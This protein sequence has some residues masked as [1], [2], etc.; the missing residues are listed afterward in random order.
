MKRVPIIFTHRVL[1]AQTL[2]ESSCDPIRGAAVNQPVA[3]CKILK[4]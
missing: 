3:S 4:S 2:M 1:L